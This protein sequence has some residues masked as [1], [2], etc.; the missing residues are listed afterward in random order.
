VPDPLRVLLTGASGYV[1]SRLAA[2]LATSTDVTVRAL[3]RKPVGYVQAD[4]QLVV[5]L[6]GDPAEVVD[7]C[8]GIDTVIHLA[9]HNEIVSAAEPERAL[10]ET[11]TASNRVGEAAAAAGVGR[12]IYVSTVHTYGARIVPGAVL[13]EDDATQPRAIYAIARLTSEHLLAS[14]ASGPE[15]VIFRLTNSVGAPAHPDV[16][17]WTLVANDLCRQAATTGTMKLLSSGV[18]W[19]DFIPLADV[20]RILAATLAPGSLAPG[21]YNLAAGQPHTVRQ[22]AG[23]VQDAFEA[24]GEP[25]PELEAPPAPADAPGPY[26]VSTAR[27]E[28]EGFRAE[29]SLAG[30]LTETVKFCL[31]HRDRL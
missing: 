11:I 7:A 8:R 23:M 2:E 31:A 20:C 5:D 16:N 12:L 21:T 14:V 15:V 19:R 18:Q 22:L 3:V 30:A 6:L 1:G 17:R 10:L 24:E 25:R 13:R 28:T 4:S 9:G 29:V 26:H 27:L